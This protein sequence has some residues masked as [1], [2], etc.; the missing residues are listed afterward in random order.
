MPG[1]V[2]VR[3]H[4]IIAKNR[5]EQKCTTDKEV[6]NETGLSVEEGNSF[7]DSEGEVFIHT[8]EY[9]ETG[10]VSVG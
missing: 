6:D 8:E 2:I 3:S 1:A 10:I 5:V 7:R 9:R 4:H